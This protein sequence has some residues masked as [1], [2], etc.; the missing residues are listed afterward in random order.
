MVTVCPAKVSMSILCAIVPTLF[1]TLVYTRLEP[2]MA[3]GKLEE[4]PEIVALKPRVRVAV[5]TVVGVGVVVGDAVV[6]MVVGAGVEAPGEE[7]VVVPGEVG[8]VVVVVP[9]EVG[10]VVVVVIGEE[11]VIVVGAGVEAPGEEVVVVPGEVG[12]V[13]VVTALVVVGVYVV[14]GVV[15]VVVPALVVVG[16]E[17]VVVGLEVVVVVLVVVGVIVDGEDVV[18]AEEIRLPVKVPTPVTRS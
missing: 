11:V 4:F 10:E 17:V 15:V 8:E 9:G 12:E 16:L 7:V 6:P 5:D 2:V 1:C 13:V 18:V 3:G 14:V